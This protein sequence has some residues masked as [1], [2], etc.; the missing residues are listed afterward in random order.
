MLSLGVIDRSRLENEFRLPIHPDHF[1]LLPGPVRAAMRFEAGYGRNLGVTDDRLERSFGGVAGREELL[2][3]SDVIV[4]PK[5][6]VRDFEEMRPGAT[7]WGWPHC[8][9][10][11]DVTQVAI[12]RRLTLIG[13]EA[14][15]TWLEE[16]VRDT[17]VF[18]RNNELAGYAGV[19]QALGLIGLDG[20]YGPPAT[21]C[22]LSHG[23]ASRGAIY[24][25]Q[26]R[27]FRNLTV[28][29]Q[30]PPWSVHDKIPGCRYAQLVRGEGD[31]GAGVIGEGGRERPLVEV[32]AEAHVIVNG[33]LQ[34]T[35]RP[36]MYLRPGEE[37]RM[38]RGA[39]I[40]DI[41]CD[42]GM[43]FPFARPTS[44]EE[45][46]IEVGPIHYYAVDHSPSHLWQSASWELSKVV[47]PFVEAVLGGPEAWQ[48]NE[49]LR[50]AIEIDR[51]VI[52]NPRILSFQNRS[53]EY[54]HP[55]LSAHPAA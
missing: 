41:S 8:V 42:L 21:A 3:S 33:I 24:A 37:K 55:V 17:H 7:H 22:I 27:G 43:G 50:R 28:Y 39:L 23:S 49:T 5:P 16:G 38:R 51:G 34:D 54:P 15:H 46:L 10:Q 40:V 25:L 18:Y 36:F 20:H 14:M 13:W 53:P 48:R 26:A 44:M 6:V 29:T 19:M 2:A 12:D 45:P 9:Q 11:S 4:L 31:V 30:R 32:L 47:T 35:D 1:D 52:L